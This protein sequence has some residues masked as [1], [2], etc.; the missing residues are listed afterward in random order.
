MFGR[1]L[2]ASPLLN[3]FRLITPCAGTV[4]VA[5]FHKWIE[6]GRQVDL[7]LPPGWD[8]VPDPKQ[9]AIIRKV[10]SSGGILI[11]AEPV[12]DDVDPRLSYLFDHAARIIIVEISADHPVMDRHRFPLPVSRMAAL[13]W[14]I[15]EP[16]NTGCRILYESGRAAPLYPVAIDR[17]LG[18]FLDDD[19]TPGNHRQLSLGL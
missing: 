16:G 2:A 4:D 6:T 18:Y 14:A 17:W 12:E 8:G 3:G 11:P 19:G 7:V 9:E 5:V 10:K 13:Q 1:A 15:R